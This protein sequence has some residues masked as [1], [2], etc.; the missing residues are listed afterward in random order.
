MTNTKKDTAVEHPVPAEV[1]ALSEGREVTVTVSAE[2]LAEDYRLISS[3][4]SVL[5]YTSDRVSTDEQS[6]RATTLPQRNLKGTDTS[7]YNRSREH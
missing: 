5:R 6:P 1:C 2:R 4:S 3:G 7:S